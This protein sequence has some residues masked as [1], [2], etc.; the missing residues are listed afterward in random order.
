MFHV[1]AQTPLAKG[2]WIPDGWEIPVF[3]VASFTAILAVIA[4]KKYQNRRK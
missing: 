4:G 3:L 2:E 1:A